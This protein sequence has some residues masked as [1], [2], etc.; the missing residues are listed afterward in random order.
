MVSGYPNAIYDDALSTWRTH[1][2][3]TTNR[4][5][6]HVTEKLWM[7]YPTPLEL[8]DYRYLGSNFRERERL[9]RIKKRWT[10]RLQAMP[11]LERLML[12]AA[13][14]ESNDGGQPRQV[15]RTAPK[16]TPDTCAYGTTSHRQKDRAAPAP[17]PRGGTLLYDFSIIVPDVPRDPGTIA[18]ADDIGQPRQKDRSA[19]ST[20]AADGGTR[21]TKPTMEDP[22]TCPEI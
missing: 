1:T 16:C 8:H 11:A 4:G 7:N 19:P 5:G 3:M 18:E 10:A 20:P 13:I 14:A 2:F 21:S 12:A 15:Q 17:T 22:Q 9:T 6:G